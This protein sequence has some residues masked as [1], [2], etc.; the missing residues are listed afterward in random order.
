MA[1]LIYRGA[2]HSAARLRHW[3]LLDGPRLTFARRYPHRAAQLLL[4]ASDRRMFRPSHRPATEGELAARRSAGHRTV[5][6]AHAKRCGNRTL[7]GSS[8]PQPLT[9]EARFAR[10]TGPQTNRASPLTPAPQAHA[11]AAA[12]RGI[13]R[14]FNLPQP[15][16][17]A[18]QHPT[19][20]TGWP[21]AVSTT[22]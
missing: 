20:L 5:A 15:A 9:D 16:R 8:S 21:R 7:C 18:D 12:C 13:G 14:D 3:D 1:S 4:I 22:L 11:A 17:P 10:R 6:S 2:A 19:T